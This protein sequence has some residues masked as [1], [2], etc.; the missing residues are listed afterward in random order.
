[1]PEEKGE[2][3]AVMDGGSGCGGDA[4]AGVKNSWSKNKNSYLLP[5]E[6]TT[7]EHTVIHVPGKWYCTTIFS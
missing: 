1:M 4:R 5:C 7:Y 2:G 6:N 3:P